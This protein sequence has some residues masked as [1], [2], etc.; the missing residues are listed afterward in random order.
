MKSTPSSHGIVGRSDLLAVLQT[1]RP[2]LLDV[3]VRML[4][5]E[6]RPAAPRVH[7]PEQR[8]STEMNTVEP[9]QIRD[10]YPQNLRA[11]TY[12]RCA[13]ERIFQKTDTSQPQRYLPWQGWRTPDT[14]AQDPSKLLVPWSQLEG[15][16]V[17][18][19][20]GQGRGIRGG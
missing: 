13:E 8:D 4:E 15:R 14:V 2:A 19:A 20:F 5:M 10:C 17:G 18:C 1:G 9:Q 3:L 7:N 11:L 6:Q 12:W 16:P